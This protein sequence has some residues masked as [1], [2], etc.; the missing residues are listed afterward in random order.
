M[1]YHF[2]NFHVHLQE[3]KVR[4]LLFEYCMYTFLTYTSC[5]LVRLTSPSLNYIIAIGII[6][7][8]IGGMMFIQPQ[9]P[10]IVLDIFCSVS[11]TKIEISNEFTKTISNTDTCVVCHN[12]HFVVLC[13]D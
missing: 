5:R 3:A 2:H 8:N 6:M 9:V 1:L 7:F 10:F 11:C 12:W 4:S 13:H